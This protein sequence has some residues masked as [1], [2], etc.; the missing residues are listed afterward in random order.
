MNS[1][2]S[3]VR[4]TKYDQGQRLLGIHVYG[5]KFN[6]LEGLPFRGKNTSGDP[7]LGNRRGAGFHSGRS[8]LLLLALS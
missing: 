3:K 8:L 6:L 7:N 5:L 1:C 4:F 2:F